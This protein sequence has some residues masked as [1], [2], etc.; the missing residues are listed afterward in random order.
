MAVD[1][2]LHPSDIKQSH[3]LTRVLTEKRAES[4]IYDVPFSPLY[5]FQG[6]KVKLAIRKH[7]GAGLAPFKADNANTPIMTGSG[8]LQEQYLELVCIAEKEV[9]NATDLIA[10]ESPD[11]QMAKLA[12]ETVLD[13]ALRLQLRNSNRTRWMAWAAAKDELTI[14]YSQAGGDVTIAVDF[15]LNGD[16]MNEGR[17][18]ASHLPTYEDMSVDEYPWDN[19]TDGVYDADIIEGV[20]YCAKLI[21]DDLGIDETEV[22][23]HINSTTYRIIKKNAGIRDELS[24]T[25]P[26]VTTPKR[27]EIVEI[28]ELADVRIRNDHYW[29]TAGSKQK[30]LPDGYALFTPA[31]YEYNG[32]PIM[33]M[34]DGLVARVVNGAIVVERN[35]GMV[36]EMYVNEEQVAQNVRV[37]TARMPVMNWASAF[38]Y[39]QVYDA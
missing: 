1:E 31:S 6:R 17:F 32:V 26:R 20:Y 38:V 10:L 18:S 12:A 30:L 36:A 24:A 34:Y 9:L 35:P 5:P 25:N 37:Q 21:A 19:T 22:A 13:K 4:T 11:E 15:D 29:D 27:E 28:L 14:T 8:E 33:E 7:F 3:I 23:M 39:A 16:G 2:Y